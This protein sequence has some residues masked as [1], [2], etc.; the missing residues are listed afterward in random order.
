M[1]AKRKKRVLQKTKTVHLRFLYFYHLCFLRETRTGK[2]VLSHSSLKLDTA[3]GKPCGMR[4][5]AQANQVKFKR[6]LRRQVQ[7]ESPTSHNP[8]KFWHENRK[9]FKRLY[10]V[11]RQILCAPASQAPVE[12][13]FSISGHILSQRRLRNSDQNFGNI[14]FANVNFEVFDAEL[15]KRK[16][17]DSDD[18]DANV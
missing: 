12:C 4:R 2:S 16:Q 17:P 1:I 6:R 18:D 11:S 8:L 3:I 7:V 14:L 5:D 15:R 10:K 9:Q 13:L